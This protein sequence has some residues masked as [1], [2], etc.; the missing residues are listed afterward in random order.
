[1]TTRARIEAN[2]RNAK[3]S[4][5]P[6]TQAGKRRVACNALRHG[7]S[8]PIETLPDLDVTVT[9]LARLIAGAKGNGSRLESARRVAE[10]QMNLRR[11]RTSKHLLLE[12]AIS[13]PDFQTDKAFKARFRLAKRLLRHPGGPDRSTDWQEWFEPSSKKLGEAERVASIMSDL[14]EKLA[15]LD[16]YERRALSRR[17]FAVREMDSFPG[18]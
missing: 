8:V 2:R 13:D 11:I 12:T 18:S 7:F 17:K 6:R 15:R 14:A 10:A 9:R 5:G 16:R 1:M 4:T 3:L